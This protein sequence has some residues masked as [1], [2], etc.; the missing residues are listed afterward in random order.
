MW[1]IYICLLD[2]RLSQYCVCADAR[3][4]RI[5]RAVVFAVTLLTAIL[6][7]IMLD[8]RSMTIA[9]DKRFHNCICPI[10]YGV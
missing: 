10:D 4:L 2:S 9:G 3:L 7:G 6:F 8:N 5:L 1:Q